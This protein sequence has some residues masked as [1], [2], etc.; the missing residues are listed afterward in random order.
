MTALRSGDYAALAAV[1]ALKLFVA[2]LGGP[3]LQEDSGLY[4]WFADAILDP[5]R[6]WLLN[7]DWL[8]RTYHFLALRTAGY[9]LLLAAAKTAAGEAF[10]QPIIFLQTL[11]TFGWM[12]LAYRIAAAV[13]PSMAWRLG[14]L[15]LLTTSQAL[16]FDL[17]VMTDSL[18]A[19]LF[20]YSCL[21]P[22]GAALGIWRLPLWGCALLGLAWGYSVWIRDA[23]VYFIFAPLIPLIA[24]GARRTTGFIW[25]PAAAFL[26]TALLMHGAYLGW[27]ELRFGRPIMSIVGQHNWLRPI[28]DMAIE[29]YAKP[30]EDDHLISRIVREKNI[31]YPWPDHLQILEVLRHEHGQNPIEIMDT[32][33]SAYIHYV[34]ANPVG[35]A[36]LVLHQLM[37]DRLA[38]NLT[39]PPYTLNFFFQYGPLIGHRVEPGVRE[40]SKAL[41]HDGD[42]AAGLLLLLILAGRALSLAL[43]ALFA[44]GVPWRAAT[45]YRCGGPAAPEMVAAYCWFI[46]FAFSGLYALVHFEDRHLLPVAPFG[47]L[48]VLWA[49][50]QFV[51]RRR[52]GKSR[53]QAA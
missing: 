40:L 10:G 11:V 51:E 17:V 50:S 7:E 39:N 37:L 25:A 49:A 28:F 14:F 35:Y 46:F 26:A 19:A 31:P 42:V 36:R 43:F 13:L 22:L 18:Y 16:L 33:K 24:W 3:H 23:G 8:T 2:W 20:L 12:L 41:R 5:N 53:M 29:G 30:F 34:F 15:A 47:I 27:S 4:I 6:S 32:V 45:G 44:V 52:W 38:F 48:G 9:P 21:L 1:L